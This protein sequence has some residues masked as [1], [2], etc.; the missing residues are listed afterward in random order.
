MSG[1]IGE[2]KWNAFNLPLWIIVQFLVEISLFSFQLYLSIQHEVHAHVIKL[3]TPTY[4][5]STKKSHDDVVV[6]KNKSEGDT[7]SV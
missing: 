3:K 2:T 7:I 1:E 6:D 5:Q 4:I